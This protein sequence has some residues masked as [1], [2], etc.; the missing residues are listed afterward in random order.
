MYFEQPNKY[1]VVV[2]DA[3]QL[4]NLELI[5][6]YVNKQKQGYDVKVLITVRDY[7]IDKVRAS[8]NSITKY[9]I[10]GVKPLT[11]EEIKTLLR[12]ALGI[13]NDSYL[14]RIVRIADGN[15]RMAILAGKIAKE[16]NKLESIRKLHGFL[17]NLGKIVR[18]WTI[19]QH[20]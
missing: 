5:I 9:E 1:F 3:N 7:A 6:E 16:S 19:L 13:L 14:N 15:A 11:D 10:I 12:E 17:K 8:I 2:D 20:N 18:M 4:S